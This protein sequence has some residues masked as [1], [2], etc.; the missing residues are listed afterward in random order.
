M[1]MTHDQIYKYEKLVRKSFSGGGISV[2]E[3]NFCWEMGVA[4][5][6]EISI[7]GH[8]VRQS[9]RAMIAP[10]KDWPLKQPYVQGEK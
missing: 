3:T 9:E 5:P 6:E 1:S 7:L 4:H 10:D 2:E 8:N